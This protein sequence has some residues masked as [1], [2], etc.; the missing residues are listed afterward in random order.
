MFFSIIVAIGKQRQIGNNNKLPWGYI[1]DDMR[2]FKNITKEHTIV[3]GR[4]TYESIGRPLPNRTN[5]ILTRQKNFIANDCIVLNSIDDLI[6]YC[7]KNCDKNEEIFI[8]GGEQIYTEILKNYSN[9]LRK[10]YISYI[11]YDGYGDAF[12]PEFDESDWEIL[13]EKKFLKS[14]KMSV[15]LYIKFMRKNN[16]NKR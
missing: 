1:E 4:K 5:I 3:M 12:F 7:K 14:E 9:F 11:N 8:I 10:M 15:V 13:E 2:N 16:V 6:E